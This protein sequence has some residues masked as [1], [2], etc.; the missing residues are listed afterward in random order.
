LPD[1]PPTCGIALGFDRLMMLVL[2]A[3]SIRE[4][5]AFAHDEA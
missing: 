4:V 2:G 5:L 1:L 3:S